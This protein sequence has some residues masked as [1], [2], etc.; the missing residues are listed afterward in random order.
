MSER[1]WSSYSACPAMAFWKIVGFDV[2]PRIPSSMK[3]LSSPLDRYPLLRLS[4]HGLW[5]CSE[6]SRSS[7]VIPATLCLFEPQSKQVGG[8][9]GT[10][11]STTDAVKPCMKLW[12]PM[13]PS[14]PAQNMPAM[15]APA[16]LSD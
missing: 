6:K 2:I 16:R 14:S 4:S 1:N 3:R 12:C 7:R 9:D 10:D 15:G 8:Y 11:R 5:P 13:G